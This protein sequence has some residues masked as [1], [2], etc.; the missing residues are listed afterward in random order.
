MGIKV[1][2]DGGKGVWVLGY[3]MS[4]MNEIRLTLRLLRRCGSNVSSL[5][6]W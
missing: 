5:V 6:F 3:V 4:G 1:A 2:C